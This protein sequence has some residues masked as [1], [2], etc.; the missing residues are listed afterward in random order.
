MAEEKTVQWWTAKRRAA[1]VLS[2]MRRETS[3]QEAG[4]PRCGGVSGILRPQR[5]RSTDV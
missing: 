5:T 4:V 1:L 3:V 2:I